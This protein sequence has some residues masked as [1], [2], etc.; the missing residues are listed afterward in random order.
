MVMSGYATWG[1]S[2][3]LHQFGSERVVE[4]GSQGNSLWTAVTGVQE[5]FQKLVGEIP[6][7]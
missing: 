5:L 4:G 6:R 3:F 2:R 1:S 7:N